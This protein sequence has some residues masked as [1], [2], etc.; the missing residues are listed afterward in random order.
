MERQKRQE[1]SRETLELSAYMAGAR[2]APLPPDVVERTKLHVL[3]AFAAMIS[4]SR[5]SPGVLGRRFVAGGGGPA[6]SCVIGSSEVVAESLA[7]MANGM[8]AHSDE[9]DD[10]HFS[11]RMHPGAAIVPAALAVGERLR[12]D[13]AT[14]L[15]AVALGY[16]VGAR[17][18]H[19]LDMKGFAGLHRSCHSFGGTFGAGAA[20]GRGL[21]G[22][23]AE[24]GGSG[25]GRLSFCEE[26]AAA[27][28][29]G[30]AAEED[31]EEECLLAPEE[32]WLL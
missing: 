16:D 14:F 18:V 13:G 19:A 26:A 27:G 31:E 7:A 6:Q 29:R 5:L 23:G 20:A 15:R 28:D 9:T 25:G 2:E 30:A 32:F 24:L 22:G 1:I 12:C 17:L 21:L 8:S 4:G 11:A 3:D 10:S